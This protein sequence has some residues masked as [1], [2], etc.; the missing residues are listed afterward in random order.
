MKTI[1][2]HI[3][4]HLDEV[5]AIWLLKRY[6]PEFQD[7]KVEFIPTSDAKAAD[8]PDKVNVG[9]GRGMFDEHKGDI[10][11][12]AA[13]LIFRHLQERGVKFDSLE[14]R[15]LAKLVEWVREGDTGLLGRMPYSTFSVHS[16]LLYHRDL[17]ERG[18]D[19]LMDI[20]FKICD[21]LLAAQKDV[22]V[23]EEDW[24][25]RTEFTSIYGPAVAFT[26]SARD[27][28]SFA[29]QHGFD[30]VAFVS[31]ERNYHNIRAFAGSNIDLTP[32][33]LQVKQVEPNVP[34]YLH[35]SKKMLICG[36]ERTAIKDTSKLTLDWIVD[37]LT[38]NY[39]RQQRY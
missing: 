35:H 30:L 38:P 16:I 4:P 39:V 31:K 22:A 23:L 27:A 36:G 12:C 3:R 33:Y 15:G 19:S 17:A 9:I 21:S 5:L 32:I 8:G 24:D 13:S 25:K 10:H 18:D 14:L 26:T 11:D 37:A 20:G 2:T 29:Y 1:V 7:A 34:W 6:L 28:D